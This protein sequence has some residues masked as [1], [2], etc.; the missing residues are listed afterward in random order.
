MKSKKNDILKNKNTGFIAP[1]NYLSE[2]ENNF[3]ENTSKLDSGF[4]SPKDYFKTIDD[5]I[6]ANAKNSG[7]QTPDHYFNDVD[8]EILNEDKDSGVIRLFKPTYFKVI[9]YSIAASILLFIGFNNFKTNTN[10]VNLETVE[11]TEIESWIDEDLISFSSFDIAEI[12]DENDIN[13]SNEY[14]YSDEEIINY[15]NDTNIENLTIED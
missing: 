15:L 7:F 8:N 1:E 2:F 12:F 13:F 11:V 4:T 10:L 5:Q 3:Q 9:G 6:I 14:S